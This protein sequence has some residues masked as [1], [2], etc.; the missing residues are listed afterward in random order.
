MLPFALTLS[1]MAERTLAKGLGS[2]ERARRL[3]LSLFFRAAVGIERIFHF[4][5]LEDVG[6]SARFVEAVL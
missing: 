3:V 5:T 2:T 1:R 4:E 6:P